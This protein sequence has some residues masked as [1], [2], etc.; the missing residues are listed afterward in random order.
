MII[1]LFKFA[2]LQI[3]RNDVC[4][5]NGLPCRAVEGNSIQTALQVVFTIAGAVSV[6][7]II[8]AGLRYTISAGNPQEAAKAKN[9][10]LYA[11]IGLVV[12]IL[13]V[14]IVRFVINRI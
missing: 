14:A 9:A 7:I 11:I 13:G 6:I 10:I 8:I 2:Q 1:D 5:D 4:G 12:C 3:Q